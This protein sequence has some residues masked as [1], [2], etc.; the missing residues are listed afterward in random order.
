MTSLQ[1]TLHLGGLHHVSAITS[2][3]RANLDFYTGILGV[4]L[5]KKTVNQ[6]DVSAY[7]LF[8]ADELGS[9]GT[10]LTFF[11]W[12]P[13]QKARPGGG[14]VTETAFRVRGDEATLQLWSQWL[15]RNGVRRGAIEPGTATRLPSLP[16]HD[17]EGLSLRLIAEPHAAGNGAFHPWNGSPIPGQAAIVGLSEVTLNVPNAGATGALLSDALGFRVHPDDPSLFETGPGGPGAQLRL[18]ETTTPGAPGGGGV[19]HVA[20]RVADDAAIRAWEARLAEKRVRTS[21]LIDRFYF[22]SLYFRIPGGILFEIATDGPGFTADGETVDR[23]GE[24]LS[25][26]PFLEHARERIE[27][28]LEPLATPA[29]HHE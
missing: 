1:N 15:G 27:A 17:P 19:H 22:R 25:L 23:L 3:A 9:P 18:Y 10:E 11:E 14:V 28:G 29:P 8:Y 16:F 7:H 5:V 13:I 12:K 26:P 2:D 6:D 24:R 21:G 20:W 4:R